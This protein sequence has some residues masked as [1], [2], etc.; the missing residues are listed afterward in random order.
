MK[1]E[2]QC[3]QCFSMLKKVYGEPL[4]KPKRVAYYCPACSKQLYT[5]RTAEV[6]KIKLNEK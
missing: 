4:P 5:E 6:I 2:F 3:K 1:D